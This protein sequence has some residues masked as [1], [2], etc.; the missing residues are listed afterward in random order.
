MKYIK[1]DTTEEKLYVLPLLEFVK[2]NELARPKGV[3]DPMWFRFVNLCFSDQ[4]KIPAIIH[5]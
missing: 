1:K 3:G 4:F 5:Y 2:E